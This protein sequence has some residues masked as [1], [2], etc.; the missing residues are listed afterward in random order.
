M[1]PKVWSTNLRRQTLSL[2]GISDILDSLPHPSL[3]TKANEEILAA[4]L[5]AINICGYEKSELI[6]S[7][8]RLVFPGLDEQDEASVAMRGQPD[9]IFDASLL[10]R[11]QDSVAVTLRFVEIAGDKDYSLVI[12]DPVAKGHRQQRELQRRSNFLAYLEQLIRAVNNQDPLMQ[13]ISIGS[14]LL[15]TNAI[16]IYICENDSPTF[17]K[18]AHWGKTNILP[19]EIPPSDLD[20]LLKPS[21]WINGQ[22]SIVT[23]LHQAVRVAQYA[24]LATVPIGNPNAL[25]GFVVTTG[26]EMPDLENT[27]PILQIMAEA[28]NIHLQKHILITNLESSLTENTQHLIIADTLAESIQEGVILIS[29]DFSIEKLNS[30]AEYMLGYTSHE[31]YEQPVENILV[32]TERLIPAI[33]L[34]FQGVPTHSLGKA[35]LHRRDGST[36]PV[37]IHTAPAAQRDKIYGVLVILQ[38]ISEHEQ[39]KIRTQQLEQRALLGEVTAVFAHEVRNPIN[40]ISTGLQLMALDTSNDDSKNQELITRL[41][42]DCAR[43][44]DL[45]E[46]ILTFSR[47]GNYKFVPT[48]VQEIIE[49]LIKRWRPRLNR[50]N[51]KHHVQVDPNTPSINGDQRGLEQVFT[52]LISNAVHAMG[53]KGGTLA[54]RV[55]PQNGP[56]GKRFT[57]IDISDTGPGIPEEIRDRIFDPFFTTDPNGTGLGLSITKQIITAHKGSIFTTSFP[58]GTVFHVQIPAL[59]TQEEFSL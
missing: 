1:I 21:L 4:N 54:I 45:M 40:N 7:A 9:H 51:I 49:R 56:S 22:R 59:E 34:A 50:L 18:S 16:A 17:R 29:P 20:H 48:D 23:M 5:H 43:L 10:T 37:L 19:N 58:G 11:N 53:E 42:Q 38:D 36:F 28:I 2:E 12:F 32:G 25:A 6:G 47:T 31:I 24:Y 57:Q 33:R 27:L 14:R 13:I 8:L 46:S 41:Q 15:V 30:A 35:V 3:L 44:T 39:A 26:G 55:K 52:N